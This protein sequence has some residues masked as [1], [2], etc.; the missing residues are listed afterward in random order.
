MHDQELL[1]AADRVH[2]DAVLEAVPVPVPA[3]VEDAGRLLGRP[4][5]RR[6]YLE[7]ADGGSGSGVLGVAGGC[8]DDPNSG[9]PSGW[10]GGSTAGSVSRCRRGPLASD[11]A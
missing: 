2:R 7:V 4:L 5:L 1:Q 3:T 6:L 10:S 8:T 11:P 9:L